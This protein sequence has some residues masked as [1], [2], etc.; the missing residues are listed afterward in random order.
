MRTIWALAKKDLRLLVRDRAGLFFTL[1][2]PVLYAIFFGTIFNTSSSEPSAIQVLLL[3]EDQTDA[4]HE[5]DALLQTD[6]NLIITQSSDRKEAR[7]LVRQGKKA[8][9]IVVPKG[10]EE[11]SLHI[12]QGTPMKLILGVDPSRMAEA[13]LIE[14]LLTAKAYQFMQSQLTDPDMTKDMAASAIES[15]NQ[16]AAKGEISPMRKMVL[17]T[18]LNSLSTF[19]TALPKT[20][21]TGDSSKA[22]E[23][24]AGGFNPITIESA[25]VA[26]DGQDGP[27]SYF[28]ISFAQGIV[29]GIMACSASFAISLV[30]ERTHGTLRRLVAAPMG[31]ARVLMGKAVACFLATIATATILLLLAWLGFGVVP[32]SLPLLVLAVVST[33]VAFVGIMMLLSVVGKT[34]ASAGGIGWAV[35][36]VMSMFGGG[37]VPLMFMKGWMLTVSNLSPVKWAIYALEGAIWRDLSF[38]QMLLPCS[39]L[40][41]V[42]VVGFGAGAKLFG[43]VQQS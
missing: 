8:A 9:F 2:F 41:G 30:T 40:I 27:P 39:I 29:W 6:E 5:L 12:F 43:R 16:A 20:N 31:Q 35:L 10:F 11:D 3:D 26:A 34:E 7:D 18:F 15:V 13:G 1:V 22:S 36:L 32:V 4:S 21:P 28:A 23:N 14:G 42:G 19:T 25:P 38:S 33:A 37:M 24:L 17:N